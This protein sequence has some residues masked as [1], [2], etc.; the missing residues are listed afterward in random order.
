MTACLGGVREADGTTVEEVALPPGVRAIGVAAGRTQCAVLVVGALSAAET[1]RVTAR[2]P[3]AVKGAG[4]VPGHGAG[5]AMPA[6]GSESGTTA[7]DPELEARFQQ[8]LTLGG[9]RPGTAG[10]RPGTAGSRPCWLE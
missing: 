1:A 6:M 5:L 9:S 4:I 7:T 8:I 2:A 3:L 10:S